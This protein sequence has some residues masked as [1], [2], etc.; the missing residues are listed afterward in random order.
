MKTLSI[1]LL[2]V[3]L[4][5][6]VAAQH[7]VYVPVYHPHVYVAPYYGIGF[8]YA[9][10]GYPYY[11]YPY[12]YDPYYS[13]VPYKLSLEIQSIKTDY[14]NKIREA[15]KDKSISHSARRQEIRNLKTQRD[16][17]IYSAEQNFRQ[18]RNNYNNQNNAPQNRNTAPQN[19]SYNGS[20]S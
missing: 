10:F 14:R 3:M 16:E 1:I 17:D 18:R 15:R 8:A 4:S 12:G 7:R 20:N 13:R 6:G 11:G 9:P 19:N 5:L 2:S